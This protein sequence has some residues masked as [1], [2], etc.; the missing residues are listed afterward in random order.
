MA[1]VR[2]QGVFQNPAL[3]PV[4]ARPVHGVRFGADEP[5]A[6]AVTPDPVQ[7]VPVSKTPPKPKRPGFVRRS[8]NFIRHHNTVKHE[9]EP[10]KERST[11]FKLGGILWGSFLITGAGML[12]SHKISS[13][14]ISQA[15]QRIDS[16]YRAHQTLLDLNKAHS[17]E[18]AHSELLKHSSGHL[19][20][21]LQELT[22]NTSQAEFVDLLKA[23][24]LELPAQDLQAIEGILKD[25]PTSL[26]AKEAGLPSAEMKPFKKNSA[27]MFNQFV[28]QVLIRYM[29]PD[30]VTAKQTSQQLKEM[31]KKEFTKYPIQQY[32]NLLLYSLMA[33]CLYVGVKGG[34]LTASM[35]TKRYTGG[36]EAIYIFPVDLVTSL[37]N[38]IQGIRE[39]KQEAKEAEIHN[40]QI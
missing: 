17:P 24:P 13:S 26:S 14:Q 37:K 27:D 20:T 32:E 16:S 2:F 1:G 19:R 30:P 5:S 3:S 23:V 31:A 36:L 7:T 15:G 29:G 11:L 39:K 22:K 6:K 18:E 10:G 8:I 40:Y 28:D 21:I 4:L 9:M 25:H 38:K 34:W 35:Q 33:V 12:V